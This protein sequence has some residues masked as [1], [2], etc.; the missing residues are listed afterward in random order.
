LVAYD[1]ANVFDQLHPGC[2]GEFGTLGYVVPR[3]GRHQLLD[4][5]REWR[6][7]NLRVPRPRDHRV[8]LVFDVWLS[9]A[10]GHLHDVPRYDPVDA[11]G[12]YD[13][14]H[15]GCTGDRD[16]HDELFRRLCARV[17]DRLLDG[18]CMCDA[19]STRD[20]RLEWFDSLRFS[21]ADDHAELLRIRKR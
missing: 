1:A 21:R 14:L 19:N 17:H 5:L 11:A 3:S 7:D 10:D 2:P 20:H 18:D 16:L 8:K 13:Q 6:G 15:P 4:Q 12:L 9:G